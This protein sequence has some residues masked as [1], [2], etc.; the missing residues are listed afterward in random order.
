MLMTFE[1]TLDPYKALEK[2]FI[3]GRED[4]VLRERDIYNIMRQVDYVENS[5]YYL[6]FLERNSSEIFSNQD[7][8]ISVMSSSVTNML[9]NKPNYKEM[10]DLIC[11]NYLMILANCSISLID[12]NGVFNAIRIF[13]EIDRPAESLISVII[14]KLR[15]SYEMNDVTEVKS[16]II[17]HKD[18][19][20]SLYNID[21]ADYYSGFLNLSVESIFA[22]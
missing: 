8:T 6:S 11:K 20:E 9:F 16:I 22:I 14:T 15:F 4:G 1:S 17:N 13:I 2:T 7:L 5:D 12:I 3:D 19:L 21:I 18:V 10:V